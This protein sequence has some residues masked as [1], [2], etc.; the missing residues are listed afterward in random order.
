ME[1]CPGDM[2]SY[3]FGSMMTQMTASQGICNHRQK[4]IDALFSEFCHFD[5]RTV[6]DLMDATKLSCEQNKIALRAINL[7]NE[8]RSGV[9]KGRTCVNGSMQRTMYMK[10]ETASPM[11]A[12]DALML[13]LM[14][15][16]F[17]QRDV[18]TADVVGMYLNA[19]MLDFVLLRLVGETIN[20]MCC[21]NPRYSSFVVI[22]GRKKVLYLSL[23]R[24]CMVVYSQHCCGTQGP[25][26]RWILS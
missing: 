9:L 15:D 11:V 21:I 10:E 22:K 8:K 18:A 26:R 1:I 23:L 7:I 16:A 19:E 17:E 5:G 24:Y 14:I 3:I 4:A 13:S 20:I 2:F 25:C 12:T 6:L